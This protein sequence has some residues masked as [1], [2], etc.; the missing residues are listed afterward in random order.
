MSRCF[1]GQRWSAVS[2]LPGVLDAI[3]SHCLYPGFGTP[4][5]AT[6]PTWPTLRSADDRYRS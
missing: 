4:Q 6:G 2:H 1:F 5:V 3:N